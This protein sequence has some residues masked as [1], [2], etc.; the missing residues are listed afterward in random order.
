ML[1]EISQKTLPDL[2]ELET[3]VIDTDVDQGSD[4]ETI[5]YFEDDYIGKIIP[6]ML[7]GQQQTPQELLDSLTKIGST[8]SPPPQGDELLTEINLVNEHETITINDDFN[9]SRTTNGIEITNNNDDNSKVSF[10]KQTP[11][12]PKQ[13]SARMLRNKALTVEINADVL[14]N[15]PSFTADINIDETDKNIK[16][17]EVFDRIINQ[18]PPDKDTVYIDHNK[19]VTNVG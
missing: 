5:N 19:K 7:D 2:P 8:P 9:I 14:E 6:E 18:L 1:T 3:I 10:A 17:E 12:Y 16:Q 11:Q 15:Y 4:T 13:R